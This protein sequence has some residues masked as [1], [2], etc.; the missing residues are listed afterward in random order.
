MNQ[1][2]KNRPKSIKKA[3]SSCDQKKF[4]ST[5][6]G[7]KLDQKWT[8]MDKSEKNKQKQKFT[9]IDVSD[10]SRQKLTKLLD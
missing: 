9:L 3:K 7:Q 5:E 6:I 1:I 4:N 10:Y 2:D 8:Q